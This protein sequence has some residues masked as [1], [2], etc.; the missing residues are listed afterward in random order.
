MNIANYGY[1]GSCHVMCHTRLLHFLVWWTAWRDE[2]CH[3]S[4]HS[5]IMSMLLELL[6]ASFG[7]YTNQCLNIEY[8]LYC[9]RRSI[10]GK[11]ACIFLMYYKKEP[12]KMSWTES[13]KW[14]VW[15]SPVCVRISEQSGVHCHCHWWKHALKELGMVMWVRVIYAAPLRLA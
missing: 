5:I 10:R 1:L 6:L 15:V 8:S 7:L 9:R 14:H 13:D 12:C 3:H 11:S 4:T 2:S